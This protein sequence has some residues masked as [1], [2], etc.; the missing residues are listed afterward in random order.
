MNHSYVLNK[1]VTCCQLHFAEVGRYVVNETEDHEKTKDTLMVTAVDC[2]LG[3]QI[4][5]LLL[6]QSSHEM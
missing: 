5:S 1:A 4:P 6:P 2:C 3:N